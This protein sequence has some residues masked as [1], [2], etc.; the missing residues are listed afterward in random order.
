MQNCST[1]FIRSTIFNLIKYKIQTMKF[2]RLSLAELETLSQ[3]FIHFLAANGI[4]AEEWELIKTAK[5]ARMDELLDEFSDLVF[6]STVDNAKYFLLT[7]NQEI[8]A[9]HCDEKA[10]QLYNIRI[11]N[12]ADFSFLKFKDLPTAL[13]EIPNE[14]KIEKF[15]VLRPYRQTRD[16]EVFALLES[17]CLIIHQSAFETIVEFYKRK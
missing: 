12:A 2:R 1:K 10:S 7:D 3:E 13:A 5:R 6:Q 11:T 9:F 15:E 17:G 16:K 14:A 8:I 4:P